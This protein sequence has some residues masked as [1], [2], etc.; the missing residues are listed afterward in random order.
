[1][2]MARKPNYDF[3][4]KERER[5]KAEKKAKRAAEKKEARDEKSRQSEPLDQAGNGDPGPATE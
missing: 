2:M 1:M 3:E 4:R 5:Q